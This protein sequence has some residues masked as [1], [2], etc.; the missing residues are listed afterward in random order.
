MVAFVAA[1]RGCRGPG[2][3]PLPGQGGGLG[4]RDFLPGCGRLGGH[5]SPVSFVPLWAFFSAVTCRMWLARLSS[6]MSPSALSGVLGLLSWGSRCH[7]TRIVGPPFRA[8]A[9][10][11]VLDSALAHDPVAR[12]VLVEGLLDSLAL[13]ELWV[14]FGPWCGLWREGG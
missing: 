12:L 3:R 13:L 8:P 6:K 1:G 14:C 2:P 11:A 4:L 10:V 7:W 5:C 9:P